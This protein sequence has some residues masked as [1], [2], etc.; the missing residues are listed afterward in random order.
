VAYYDAIDRYGP[1]STQAVVAQSL[2]RV[3]YERVLRQLHTEGALLGTAGNLSDPA[4]SLLQD[5]ISTDQ[6]YANGFTSQLPQMSREAALART[7]MYL[8][9]QI[10]TINELAALDLPTLPIYP[11]DDRL[12]CT[13]YCKCHLD[14]RYLFG[15]GNFDVYWRMTPEAEHCDDCLQLAA[16]WNPLPIRGWQIMRAKQLSARELSILKAALLEVAA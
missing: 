8:P 9:T 1:D 7:Q 16:M 2:A 6:Y 13:H 14:I 10:S 4:R 5:A 15:E 12:I 3:D 11:Q